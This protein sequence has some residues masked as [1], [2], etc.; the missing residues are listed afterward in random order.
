MRIYGTRR[1]TDRS[2]EGLLRYARLRDAVLSGRPP[3]LM[4]ARYEIAP[5]SVAGCPGYRIGPKGKC[6]EKAVLFLHGGVFVLQITPFH[7]RWIAHMIDMLGVCVYVP[8]YPL[9]PRER[10]DRA[11]DNLLCYYKRILQTYGGTDI[12][13]AGDS[14]GGSLCLSLA[15]LARDRA[16][17]LPAR[18]VLLSP[19]CSLCA[20]EKQLEAMRRIEKCDVMLSTKMIHTI[21]RLIAQDLDPKHYLA[22]PLYGDFS[23]LPPIHIYSG[24][25]DILFVQALLLVDRL[26]KYGAP[27]TFR[28]AKDRMHVWALTPC[29]EGRAGLLALIR[30]VAGE[31]DREAESRRGVGVSA[32][33]KEKT[34]NHGR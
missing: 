13:F 32:A 7:Y 9:A 6:A 16:L 30:A 8:L 29:R 28:V 5:Y 10:C 4:Y 34:V 21:P 2:Y 24:T 11:L 23:G 18:L 20:T 22:S 14:A 25:A 27:Y 19:C 33:G 26:K 17:P 12:T 15:M 31:W 3:R 1:I